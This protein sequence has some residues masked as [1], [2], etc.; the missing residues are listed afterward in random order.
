METAGY[1]Q[2]TA[3][4][5][6]GKPTLLIWKSGS[7]ALSSSEEV[8][9]MSLAYF[10]RNVASGERA[11]KK[12]RREG[13]NMSG[14]KLWS[15]VEDELIKRLYPNYVAILTELP[16][17]TYSACRT[18]ARTLGVVKERPPYTAKE[19]SIVRRL[20]PAGDREKLLALLPGRT[21]DQV[22]DL[23][24]RHGIRRAPKLFKPTG[25]V[26]L[27]QIRARCRE[28]NYTMPDL[29]KMIRSKGY[30]KKANWCKGHIHHRDIGRA[31]SA[32]FGDVK[33]EWK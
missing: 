3:C 4:E 32:L 19:L 13:V 9:I 6:Q 11:R 12:M 10:A 33:A 2:E 28:L 31:V 30:F 17:R 5:K 16:H 14:D 26:V 25:V 7:I 23:A 20:Y 18:R 29:D 27:D 22:G 21:W 24:K 8:R 15:A 1:A